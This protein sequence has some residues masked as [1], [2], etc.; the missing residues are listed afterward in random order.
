MYEDPKIVNKDM[1][2]LNKGADFVNKAFLANVKKPGV[3]SKF[4]LISK[5]DIKSDD[6]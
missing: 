1:D 5:F 4:G 6:F 2:S 3:C